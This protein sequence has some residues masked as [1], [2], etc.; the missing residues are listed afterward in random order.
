MNQTEERIFF[1]VAFKGLKK[2]DDT[3]QVLFASNSNIPDYKTQSTGI[4][5]LG[6]REE[7]LVYVVFKALLQSNF[8]Y[9]VC[10]ERNYPNTEKK[11]DITFLENSEV[12]SFC[13]FKV[14]RK[15][16]VSDIQKDIEKYKA[17]K[18]SDDKY[19]MIIEVSGGDM[20]ENVDYL[21]TNLPSTKVLHYA[22][23][24]TKIFNEKLQ[25][26]ENVTGKLYLIKVIF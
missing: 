10:L 2:E 14:W 5:F 18:V 17:L 6:L 19:L 13:E 22:D 15:E 3:L 11:A 16:D 1:D 7:S 24:P 26:F 23:F 21:K 4:T 20:Q 9:Q 8:P 25:A 12:N